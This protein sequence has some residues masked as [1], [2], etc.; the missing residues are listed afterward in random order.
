MENST[1]HLSSCDAWV[2]G[3]SKERP[4]NPLGAPSWL[5]HA[6]D[7]ATLWPWQQQRPLQNCLGPPA[8]PLGGQGLTSLPSHM[9]GRHP[10]Q[11]AQLTQLS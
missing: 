1:Q 8:S 5:S 9:V 4:G 3:L 2:E 10:P 7:Q 6:V 11:L